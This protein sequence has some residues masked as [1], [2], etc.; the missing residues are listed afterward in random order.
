MRPRGLA[1]ASDRPSRLHRQAARERSADIP[2][3]ARFVRC[4]MWCAFCAACDLE[5]RR[6][7]SRHTRSCCSP[8]IERSAGHSCDLAGVLSTAN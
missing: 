5:R 8:S 7:F 3:F 2:H 6:T 4:A 1:G